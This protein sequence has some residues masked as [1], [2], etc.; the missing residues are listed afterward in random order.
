MRIAIT[1][2]V[3]I[4]LAAPARADV[5]V[6]VAGEGRLTPQLGAQFEN[7]L[8]QHGYTVVPTPLPPDVIPK[9]GDCTLLDGAKDCMRRLVERGAKTTS[10]LYAQ[11]DASNNPTNGTRDVVLTAWWFDRGH[12]PV[13]ERRPCEHCNDQSLRS[14]A[15]DVMKDL[16][17]GAA[18][19]HVKLRSNPVGARINVD[20]VAV[21]ITPLDWDLPPGKHVIQMETAP[22]R[23]DVG[24]REI[25][26]VG[27]KTEI[28]TMPPPPVDPGETMSSRLLQILPVAT[29]AA[30]GALLI[31][32]G[33]MIA[34]DEDPS[35]TKPQYI[36]NTA[37][38]GVGLAIGGAVVTSVGMYLLFRSPGT[39]SAPVAAVSGDTAYVGWLGRF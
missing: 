20:G 10:M 17:G 33:V 1:I 9:L 34:V 29:V 23:N 18:V 13:A 6:V 21:G 19:G 35:R 37:P 12:A 27:D 24:N 38:T 15:D 31:A 28:I 5:G 16:L 32:G 39:S 25:V 22:G 11:I 3:W 2:A 26:V 8:S 30:G 14:I 36:H 7:W 4:A